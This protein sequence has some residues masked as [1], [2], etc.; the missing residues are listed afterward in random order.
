MNNTCSDSTLSGI[1]G[2][3]KNIVNVIQIIGPILALI[4]IVILFIKLMSNPEDKKIPKQIRNSGIALIILFF[5]PMLV[6][7]SMSLLGDSF[8]FSSCW[9]S[10]T[11]LN[12]SS[13]YVEIDG[14]NKKK[15]NNNG[16][17]E[18]GD[19]TST[20]S[21][22]SSNNTSTDGSNTD[23]SSDNGSSNNTYGTRFF[24][25]DSR[26]VQM[27]CYSH[28]DWSSSTVNNL[29]SGISEAN[30]DVWSS[31]GSIGLDWMKSTGIPNVESNFKSGSAI[32]ILMGVNDLYNINNYISY[33][34]SKT[35]TWK[36]KG[37]SIYFI[38]VNPTNG[39]YDHMNNDINSF[40]SKIKTIKGIK[41]LDTNSY[42]KSNGFNTTDGLHYDKAT[43]NKIYQYII[44]HL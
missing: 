20:K 32:I 31:K 25:G 38:S 24:I 2:I 29:S 21:N 5:I 9:N 14:K 11:K 26:T 22:S 44:S 41:Y 23:N 3:A 17:Y 19:K 33:L 7:V 6:N 16:S 28:D 8:N 15:I 4:G 42:L 13:T 43:Y 37:A 36:S 1:L 18:K 10:N 35:S 30:G 40:N 27:Y 34:N 39:S 12:G